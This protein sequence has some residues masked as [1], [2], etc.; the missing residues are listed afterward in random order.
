MQ[1]DREPGTGTSVWVRSQKLADL[2]EPCKSLGA[3]G[4]NPP[5]AP[6][7]TGTQRSKGR[8]RLRLNQLDQAVTLQ[9]GHQRVHE[10]RDPRE[11]QLK[12]TLVDLALGLLHRAA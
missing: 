5:G 2:A 12:L 3:E 1:A 9:P 7:E 8:P 11:R 6:A 4:S 10:A